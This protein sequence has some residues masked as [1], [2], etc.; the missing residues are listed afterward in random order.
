MNWTYSHT[1]HKSKEIF[2]TAT[3]AGITVYKKECVFGTR[4]GL[5][6]YSLIWFSKESTLIKFLTL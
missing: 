3:V 5:T 2:Y 4:F 6:P 1:D